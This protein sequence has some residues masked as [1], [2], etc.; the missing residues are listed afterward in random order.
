MVR[1]PYIPYRPASSLLVG[2]SPYSSPCGPMNLPP[3]LRIGTSV[4]TPLECSREILIKSTPGCMS[5]ILGVAGSVRLCVRGAGAM[6]RRSAL[7]QR[8]PATAPAKP[9]NAA[10]AAGSTR[11][12]WCPRIKP[13]AA[14]SS[15][16]LT[17]LSGNALARGAATKHASRA[18]VGSAFVAQC[19]FPSFSSFGRMTSLQYDADGFL[20]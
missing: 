7:S 6:R 4:R 5:G 3:V 15:A 1:R 8:R 11:S 17:V 10:A 18:I 13:V 19:S 16:P 20:R 2:N 9:K 14:P 12:M